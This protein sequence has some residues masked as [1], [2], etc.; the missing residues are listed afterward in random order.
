MRFV[1]GLATLFSVLGFATGAFGHASLVST[2]PSDGSMMSS[3]PKTVRLRFNEPI[4]PASIRL[5]DGAGNTRDDVSVSAHGDTIEISLPNDLPRGTQ[6]V[7]YRVVSADGHPV[8]GSLLFSLGMSTNKVIRPADRAP[9]L[10]ALVW[11]ARLGIYFGLFAGVGGAFFGAWIS[12]TSSAQ[13]AIGAALLMGCTAAIAAWGLQ[14]LDLLGLVPADIL[15]SAPWQAAASTS[16]AP[17][18]LV[19]IVAM[20]LAMTSLLDISGGTK[21]VLSAAAILGVGVALAA[22]GHASTAQPQWLTRP[23]VFLHGVGVAFWIGALAPLVAMSK[24][25]TTS[26]LVI[27]NRFSRVAMPVVAAIALTGLGLAVVQLESVR[28]LIATS[29]GLILS[30]K[31]ALVVVILALAALNRFRLTPALAVDPHNTRALVRSILAECLAGVAILAVVAGWHVCGA[32]RGGCGGRDLR[33]RGSVSRAHRSCCGSQFL[34][35]TGARGRHRRGGYSG[36]CPA[37]FCGAGALAASGVGNV[38][39]D[40]GLF[41]ARGLALHGAA[42]GICLRCGNA[43]ARTR[44]ASSCAQTRATA[45]CCAA[46]S[47][48]YRPRRTHPERRSKSCRRDVAGYISAGG[49]SNDGERDIASNIFTKDY[50]TL[51][52]GNFTR[53]L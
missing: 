3:A 47:D 31:L 44:S 9:A 29:Y 43:G 7:S 30:V 45:D 41:R 46:G 20:A 35:G 27:L 13:R 4:T 17:S 1:A 28:A 16:L 53:S 8:G 50:A 38:A 49:I 12:R 25:P 32:Q 33:R 39:G 26:L 10:D 36:F 11:L 19:A 21:R 40:A 51:P 15:S 34:D 23:M 5:I 2:E 42:G 48:D 14:G 37:R 22:S 52:A 24:R 6:V 18:L